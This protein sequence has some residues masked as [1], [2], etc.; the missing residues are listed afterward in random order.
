MRKGSLLLWEL[1]LLV[2][3]P[4]LLRNVWLYGMVCGW[5]GIRIC[6]VLWWSD[7]KLMIESI[8]GLGD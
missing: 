6:L 5:Q 2:R 7:L 3:I 1:D 4:S 8:R